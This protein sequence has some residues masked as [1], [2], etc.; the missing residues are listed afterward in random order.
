LN[1]LDFL[2]RWLLV[3]SLPL[4]VAAAILLAGVLSLLGLPA[5]WALIVIAFVVFVCA[6]LLLI[7]YRHRHGLERLDDGMPT[8]RLDSLLTRP[9]GDMPNGRLDGLLR[10]NPERPPVRAPSSRPG[11]PVRPE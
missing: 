3:W 10:A 8:G 6:P 5:A 11:P 1:V 7:F 9:R 2:P 4:A